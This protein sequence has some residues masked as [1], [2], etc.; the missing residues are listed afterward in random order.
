MAMQLQSFRDWEVYLLTYFTV[1]QD[2]LTSSLSSAV[3]QVFRTLAEHFSSFGLQITREVP[4][5]DV[6]QILQPFCRASE[7][8]AYFDL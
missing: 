2:L 7:P 1:Y 5:S 3:Q 8:S 4:V 6:R